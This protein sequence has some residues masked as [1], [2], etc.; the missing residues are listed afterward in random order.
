M[1]SDRDML[2][3]QLT[4]EQIMNNERRKEKKNQGFMN[5]SHQKTTIPISILGGNTVC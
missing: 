5:T 4:D 2:D 3:I 1:D